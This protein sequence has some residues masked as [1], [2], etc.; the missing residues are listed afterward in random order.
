MRPRILIVDDEP[1][2]RDVLRESLAREGYDTAEAANAVAAIAAV[3]DYRPHVVLLDLM[4]PGAIPGQEI[5]AAISRDVPVIIITAVTDV[6]IAR[7]SLQEG[8]FDFVTKPFDLW[9]I[10]AVVEVVL[11]HGGV[12][13]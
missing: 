7:R 3:R 2:I 11:A 8:A 6:E 4:M 5:I 13:R 1:E 12:D 10:A 9:R